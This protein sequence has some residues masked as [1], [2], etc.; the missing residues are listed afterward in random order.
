MILASAIMP[1]ARVTLQREREAELRRALREMRTAIDKYKDAV[2]TGQIRVDRHQ[3]RQR[4]LS[5][6][7]RDARRGRDEGE[8]RVRHQAQV[9]AAGPDRS[10]DALDRVGHAVVSGQA[11]LEQLGRPERLRRLHQ[12]D[13]ARRSTA[14]NT[15][16]GR[17]SDGR[18]RSPHGATRARRQQRG[19]TLIELLVVLSLISI[20]A[21]MGMV[22]HRNSVQHAQEAMLRTD[23]FHMRD[24]IDQY[25]ADKGKYPASL[26]AL[27]P[28]TTC[29]RFPRIRSPSRP[30]PGRPCRPNPIPATRP[31]S[32]A[33]TTSRAARRARRSTDRRYADW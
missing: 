9:P 33:S 21:A 11:G 30:T 2:D 19:F 14:R 13:R 23:L 1:L 20:L 29:A 28:T 4:R 24:A 27:V 5:A 25:F 12:G 3:G 10:D 16:T 17:R 22:Q 15:R 31:P 32:R 8:R 18:P 7:S 26:D 6:G